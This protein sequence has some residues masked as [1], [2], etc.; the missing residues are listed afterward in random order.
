MNAASIL[1]NSVRPYYDEIKTFGSNKKVSKVVSIALEVML[2][3]GHAFAVNMAFRWAF[4]IFFVPKRTVFSSLL[5]TSATLYLVSR[6][7]ECYF[8]PSKIKAMEQASTQAI[9]VNTIALPFNTYVHEWGHKAAALSTFINSAPKILFKWGEGKT[10]YA[11]SYGLT[12]F[13]TFLGKQNALLFITAAGLYAPTIGTISSFA[14]SHILV[15]SHPLFSNILTDIGFSQLGQILAYGLPTLMQK[16][17]SWDLEND[18]I[19]LWHVGG[20]HPL[21]MMACL[22]AIPVTEYCIL[23]WTNNSR[24]SGN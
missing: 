15:N 13:G 11:I 22:L 16:G 24:D 20:V 21:V 1:I 9:L 7:A 8:K 3:L 4:T 12:P 2:R 23:K 14:L 5:L 17:V 18:F 10:T 19:K 6:I